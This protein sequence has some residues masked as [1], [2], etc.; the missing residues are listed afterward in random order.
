MPD[1]RSDEDWALHLLEKEKVLAHPGYLF[2]FEEEK[3]LVL[4]LLIPPD[5]FKAGIGKIAAAI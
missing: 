5:E 3:F 2:D 1:T 4:S